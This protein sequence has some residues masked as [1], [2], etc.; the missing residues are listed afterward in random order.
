MSKNN[1]VSLFYFRPKRER[2]MPLHM[3]GGDFV[4]GSSGSQKD[5]LI[6]KTFEKQE[7]KSDFKLS[8]ILPSPN[9]NLPG[10]TQKRND[11]I[12]KM[13][14]DSR[15]EATDDSN[16]LGN[17]DDVEEKETDEETSDGDW[18]AII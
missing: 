7:K 5:S 14:S 9:K 12:S 16:A 11:E 6:K 2:K 8:K 3:Q 15:K 4:Y 13:T 17:E 10:N 1:N 18:Y